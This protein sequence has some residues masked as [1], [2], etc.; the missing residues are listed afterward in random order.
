MFYAKQPHYE[1]PVTKVIPL[2]A[3]EPLCSSN[4]NNKGLPGWQYDTDPNQ[5]W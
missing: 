5:S 2:P 3:N 1:R 4:Q